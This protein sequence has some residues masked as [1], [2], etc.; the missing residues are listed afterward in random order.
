VTIWNSDLRQQSCPSVLRVVEDKRNELDFF[1][2]GRSA[3]ACRFAVGGAVW[4]GILARTYRL[5]LKI[6]AEDKAEGN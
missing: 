2:L 6:V 1:V 4:S 3:S 5:R